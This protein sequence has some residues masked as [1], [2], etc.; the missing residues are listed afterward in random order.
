M[1]LTVLCRSCRQTI[2]FSEWISDRL[3][4][5]RKKSENIEIKCNMCGHTDKYHVDEISA[6]S[7]K[8]LGILSLVIIL[9]GTLFVSYVIW[10]NIGKV[11]YP[12][13]VAGLLGGG[14]IPILIYT[15]IS[16]SQ[17]DKLNRFNRH[18]V[19]GY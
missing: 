5:V 19:R 17:R 6:E 11:N 4:L 3:Q 15:T 18:K 8:F 1:T 12:Y 16:K 13:A 10:R 14:L 9:F 2:K 7:N